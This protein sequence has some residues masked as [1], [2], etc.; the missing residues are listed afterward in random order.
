MKT[1]FTRP[2][3]T[4]LVVVTGGSGKLGHVVVRHLTERGWRVRNVDTAPPRE[5][6]GAYLH[7]DL[8]DF[9]QTVEA[10]AGAAAVVHLAAIPAPGRLPPEATFRLN[11][12]STFNVFQAAALHRMQ[13]VVWASSETTLGLSFRDHPPRYTPVDEAHYPYPESTYALSKV[14]G[15]TLADQFARWHGTPHVGLRFSNVMLPEDYARFPS[16]QDD[17]AARAWNLWGYIDAR[18]AAQACRLGLEAEVTGAPAYII[19]AA[20][21]VMRAPSAQLLETTFPEVPRRR[22]VH[23]RATLLSIDRA[24]RELGYDPQ[25][26]WQDHVG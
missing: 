14:A 7:A 23:G 19:A 11:L 22:K 13:R 21:T 3:A 10:L 4:P 6:L 17:P 12:A 8:T 24:R 26:A 25:F 16:W 9:G 5:P 18:D 2:R 1:R 20:D 15:E